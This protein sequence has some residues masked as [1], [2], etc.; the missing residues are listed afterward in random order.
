[1][2]QWRLWWWWP[3]TWGLGEKK[4]PYDIA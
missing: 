4:L 3:Q 1:L 2:C